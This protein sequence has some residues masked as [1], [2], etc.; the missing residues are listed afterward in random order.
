MSR[1]LPPLNAVRAF[2]AAARLASFKKAAEELN[3]TPGAVSQQVR[4]LEDWVGVPLFRRLSRGVALTPAG[5]RYWPVLAELLDHLAK[6]TRQLRADVGPRLLTVATIPS[7]GARWLVPR[8]GRLQVRLPEL[9]VRVQIGPQLTDFR[10][11]AVD[12]VI[13]HGGGVYPGLFSEFLLKDVLFPV[14]SPALQAHGPPLRE[15]ADLARHILLHDEPNLGFNEPRWADWLAAAGCGGI[16]AE[17]GPMFS[18]THMT[19]QAALA[20]QGIALAPASQVAEE[21]ADGR[22]RRPFALSIPDPFAYWIVCPPDRANRPDIAAF[23]TWLHEEAA[24]LA[25]EDK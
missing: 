25:L 2:E 1:R 22:L 7:F 6:A 23:R 24:S 13:R 19:V 8:L 5:D 14:C 3:V 9:Q 15:P 4:Q 20:G 21:L 17:R 12:V 11:E 16:D 10:R 18:F